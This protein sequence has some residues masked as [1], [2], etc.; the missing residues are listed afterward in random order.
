MNNSLPSQVEWLNQMSMIDSLNKAWI[1]AD[2]KFA[3]LSIEDGTY[4]SLEVIKCKIRPFNFEAQPPYRA[5]LYTLGDPET[6]IDIYLNGVQFCVRGNLWHF[7]NV[8]RDKQ[9]GHDKS[10]RTWLWIDAICIDRD[11]LV[12]RNREVQ[13]MKKI[14]GGAE[15]VMSWIALL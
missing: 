8:A 2:N 9:S 11:N 14:F 12:E 1:H 3:F 13:F 15:E 5:L 7:L 10:K 6:T 4:D